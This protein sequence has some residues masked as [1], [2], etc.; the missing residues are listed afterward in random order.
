MVI[1]LKTCRRFLNIPTL[2]INEV[3]FCQAIEDAALSNL[4]KFERE[5]YEI[6]LK[7]YR[8]LKGFIDYAFMK[9]QIAG[10]KNYEENME[11]EAAKEV[12][13]QMLK[14][15]EPVEKILKYTLL[16]ITDIEKIKFDHQL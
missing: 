3:V 10:R 11:T 16:N 13:K 15:N 2:F 6:C 14:A 7:N 8:D 4:N 5:S 9:W 1:F 12:A